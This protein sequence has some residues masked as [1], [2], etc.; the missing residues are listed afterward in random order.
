MEPPKALTWSLAERKP[1][2]V[3]ISGPAEGSQAGKVAITA[4]HPLGTTH[5]TQ[6][7]RRLAL[8]LRRQLSNTYWHYHLHTVTFSVF[9]WLLCL[10][11]RICFLFICNKFYCDFV[12]EKTCLLGFSLLFFV[13]SSCNFLLWSPPVFSKFSLLQIILYV[14][15]Y[16]LYCCYSLKSV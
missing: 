14:F 7:Q 3:Y 1:R 5:L 10:W 6:S 13:F 15:S 11:Y 12:I 16:G 2:W 4:K 9:F 8:D